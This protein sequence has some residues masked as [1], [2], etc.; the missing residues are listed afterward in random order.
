MPV[1]QRPRNDAD[2]E[3]FRKILSYPPLPPA[4]LQPD[5]DGGLTHQDAL[6]LEPKEIIYP[7]LSGVKCELGHPCQID[8]NSRQINGEGFDLIILANGMGIQ[9]FEE[10]DWLPLQARLGQIENG[11]SPTKLT[12]AITSG[13]Y[14]L[15]LG[16]TRLW[17]AT[18][19]PTETTEPVESDKASAEN[20][21]AFKSLV[22]SEWGLLSDWRRAPVFARQHPTSFP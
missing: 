18:F 9:S 21:A 10:T 6:I 5:G 16:A 1:E 22:A 13:H 3:R 20:D 19:A 7:I 15:A 4:L 12:A 11:R 14:A 2:H 8:F 17:G